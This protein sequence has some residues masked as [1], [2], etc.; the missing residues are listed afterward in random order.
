MF[1]VLF[2]QK[3]VLTIFC[4]GNEPNDPNKKQQSLWT[5]KSLEVAVGFVCMRVIQ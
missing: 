3:T 5:V 2:F 4:K 1:I